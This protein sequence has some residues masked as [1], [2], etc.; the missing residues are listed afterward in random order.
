MKKDQTKNMKANISIIVI[1]IITAFIFQRNC[2]VVNQC[3]FDY[4]IQNRLPL[5]CTLMFSIY[6]Y[7]RQKAT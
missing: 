3:Q 5:G 6:S 2:K 4:E 1:N 7:F